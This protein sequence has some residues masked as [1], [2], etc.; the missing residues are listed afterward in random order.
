MYKTN[1]I[2]QACVYSALSIRQCTFLLSNMITGRLFFFTRVAIIFFQLRMSNGQFSSSRNK[3]LMGV[4]HQE[5]KDTC[6][7]PSHT[8]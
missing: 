4:Y 2:L 8:F 6:Y 7:V 5:Y 1:D 3:V